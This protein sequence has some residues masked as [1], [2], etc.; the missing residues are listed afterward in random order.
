MSST[1]QIESTSTSG[2][3]ETSVVHTPIARIHAEIEES[4]AGLSGHRTAD[5]STGGEETADEPTI[6]YSS[7]RSRAIPLS[8][9]VSRAGLDTQ[10]K[11]PSVGV[12]DVSAGKRLWG[13]FFADR[14]SSKQP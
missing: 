5:D 7:S 3:S 14:I 10:G 9:R 8:L 4:S 12:E 2:L 1:A 11:T 13:G 6:A